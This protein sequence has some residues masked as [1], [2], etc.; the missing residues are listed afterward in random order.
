MLHLV[1]TNQTPTSTVSRGQ[2]SAEVEAQ[3]QDSKTHVSQVLSELKGSLFPLFHVLSLDSCREFFVLLVKKVDS[4]Y[5][6]KY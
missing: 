3:S 4:F 2:Q 5:P 6:T 1:F